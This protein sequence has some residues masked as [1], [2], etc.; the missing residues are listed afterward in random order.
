MNKKVSYK[1]KSTINSLVSLFSIL[2]LEE[3]QFE[4]FSKKNMYFFFYNKLLIKMYISI[5]FYN[6]LIRRLSFG[7]TIYIIC[8]K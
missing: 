5:Y 6:L 4:H 2:F 1:S 8:Y 7:L 3:L